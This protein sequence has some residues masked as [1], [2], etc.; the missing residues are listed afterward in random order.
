MAKARKQKLADR[1]QKPIESAD[2]KALA[3]R[4]GLADEAG[5]LVILMQE[6]R[7]GE[8]NYLLST[9]PAHLMEQQERF[10]KIT[11]SDEEPQG[12][13]DRQSGDCPHERRAGRLGPL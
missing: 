2:G 11:D 6:S 9:D 13:H 4:T 1:L 10:E 12:A 3:R 5:R 8:L 7:V